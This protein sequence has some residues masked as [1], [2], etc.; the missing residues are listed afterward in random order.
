MSELGAIQPQK[1]ND[2]QLI[3]KS[4]SKEGKLKNSVYGLSGKGT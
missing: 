4:F 1:E 2:I 3:Y